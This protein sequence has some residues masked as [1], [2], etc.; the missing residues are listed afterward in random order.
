MTY[1]QAYNDWKYLCGIGPA[2]DMT[3]G[4]Q[5]QNDLK[6]LLDNPIKYTAK[7][8]LCSQINY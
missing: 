7:K 2:D 4:Y 6:R 3:G 1:E 5:D 8:C